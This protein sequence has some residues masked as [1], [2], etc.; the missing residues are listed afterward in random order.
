M[1]EGRVSEVKYCHTHSASKCL[2]IRYGILG[3]VTWQFLMEEERAKQSRST[4]LP[5]FLLSVSPSVKGVTTSH[6][7]F[8]VPVTQ[9]Q[10]M[11]PTIRR[12]K[13][14]G[15]GEN[16]YF[17]LGNN[18]YDLG[19]ISS[20]SLVTARYTDKETR[21]HYVIFTS[22]TYGTKP[23]EKLFIVLALY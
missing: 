21:L 6:R 15:R 3:H 7:E 17:F 9:T 5:L 16:V 12:L 1:F 14:K 22:C 11:V 4:F 2:I 8:C 20:S 10:F 18:V 23:F 19:V 13:Q